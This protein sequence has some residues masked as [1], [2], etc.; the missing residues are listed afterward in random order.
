[1]SA[2][3]HLRVGRLGRDCDGHQD[4]PRVGS[5]A[6]TLCPRL[7]GE[8]S[9]FSNRKVDLHKL[10]ALVFLG[11]F[12][13]RHLLIVACAVDVHAHRI[14]YIGPNNAYI[15]YYQS[16]I[17]LPAPDTVASPVDVQSWAE[18]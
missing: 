12:R 2:L 3:L 15:W 11:L 18:L 4:H 17:K 7:F 10:L 9:L 1:M 6:E 16:E 5:E 8:S 13:R 14:S